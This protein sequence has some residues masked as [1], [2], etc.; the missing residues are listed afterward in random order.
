MTG[1]KGGWT[2]LRSALRD[3]IL[4][5]LSQ[6]D[7]GRIEHRDGFAL[8]LLPGLCDLPDT[9]FMQGRIAPVI[10]RMADQGLITK[11][12][13][14]N[15]THEIRLAISLSEEEIDRLSQEKRANIRTARGR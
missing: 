2:E 3:L 4:L 13:R 9:P 15:R 1:S 8:S 7:E 12:T 14:G 5:A 10:A 6:Q 11:R